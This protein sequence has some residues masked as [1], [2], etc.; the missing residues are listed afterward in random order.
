MFSPRDSQVVLDDLGDKF[1]AAL[2]KATNATRGDFATFR[3]EHPDWVARMFERDLAN[4]I[5][6]RLWAHLEDELE[7]IDGVTMVAQEPTREIGISTA[8]G[9]GYVARVKRHNANDQIRSYPTMTDV[10]FWS[11]GQDTLDGFERTSLAVGY[12]WD[13]DTREIGSPVISY[14]EGKKNVVWAFA[15]DDGAAGAQPIEYKPIL[16]SLP[17]VD[18]LDA[19]RETKLDEGQAEG[20]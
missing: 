20:Q 6:P 19:S 8:G 7:G 18:L 5:H 2:L 16:P 1:P 12:R 11:G 9:R 17:G 3:Q 13:R 10:I 4:L 15:I 14:R